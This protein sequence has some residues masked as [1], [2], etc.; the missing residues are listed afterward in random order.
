M[1]Y[2]LL[3]KISMFLIA[4]VAISVIALVIFVILT[5]DLIHMDFKDWK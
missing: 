3:F 5:C 2:F 4:T 1:N